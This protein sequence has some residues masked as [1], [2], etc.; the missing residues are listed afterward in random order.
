MYGANPAISISTTPAIGSLTDC[1]SASI[2]AETRAVASRK[3]T[4]STSLDKISAITKV[5]HLPTQPRV[6]SQ[7]APARAMGANTIATTS[8]ALR[9]RRI[10]HTY[11]QSD[12]T[13]KSV[14]VHVDHGGPVG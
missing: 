7:E 4:T 5:T 10:I 6:W 9:T 14:T 12:G 1:R 11:R 2:G 8:S 3:I 13:G